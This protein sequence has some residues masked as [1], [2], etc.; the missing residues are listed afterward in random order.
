MGST[1]PHPQ[2]GRL[3]RACTSLC[4]TTAALPRVVACGRLQHGEPPVVPHAAP[5]RGGGLVVHH[6]TNSCRDSQEKSCQPSPSEGHRRAVQLRGCAVAG[7]N[8]E[9]VHLTW[10]LQSQLR[11]CLTLVSGHKRYK[12]SELIITKLANSSVDMMVGHCF[13]HRCQ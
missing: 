6:H 7:P 12:E 8:M 9:R 4:E 1:C 10:P 11:V 13:P 5:L 2:A 3:H